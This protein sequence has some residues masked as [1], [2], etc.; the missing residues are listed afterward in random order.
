MIY[1]ISSKTL[2]SSKP[3]RIT[4]N[5]I[6]G[7]IRI[8]G[9]TK[10]LVLLGLENYNAIYNRIRYLLSIKSGMI[11]FILTIMQKIAYT[12]NIGFTCYYTH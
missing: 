6:D 7:F 1:D 9:G 5:K 3:L 12:K 10:Y 8:Y 11:M 2:I 4:F